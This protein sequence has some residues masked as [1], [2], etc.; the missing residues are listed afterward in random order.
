MFVS[1]TRFKLQV[2]MKY[3]SNQ[4]RGDIRAKYILDDLFII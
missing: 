2:P 4:P 1:T 3:N